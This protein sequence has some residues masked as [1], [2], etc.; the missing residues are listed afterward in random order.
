MTPI[1][2]KI[3][4]GFHFERKFDLYERIGVTQFK[5]ILPLGSFWINLFNQV[6]NKNF[7]IITS[8]ENA[9]IWLAFTFAVELLH[10]LALIF[11]IYFILKFGLENEYFKMLKA[12]L[13]TSLINIYPI[14]VQRYNR[15]RIFE[16]YKIN[17]DEL[18]NFKIEI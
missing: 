12:I 18:I 9:L 14:L 16:I 15:I 1:L 2:K 13:F 7:H 11:S 4:K 8:R 6:F 10:I 3:I 17:K 5:K